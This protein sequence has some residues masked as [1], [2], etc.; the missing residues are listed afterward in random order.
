MGNDE[1]NCD[2]TSPVPPAEQDVGRPTSPSGDY[3]TAM[4]DGGP[5]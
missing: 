3:F 1:A 2:V 4:V 5:P